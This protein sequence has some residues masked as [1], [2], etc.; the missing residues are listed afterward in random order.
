[1]KLLLVCIS[2]EAKDL[3][4]H[5]LEPRGFDFI[6]Y[7]NPVKAMDNIDEISPELVIFSAE[8]F[9]R[10][11]KPF[12]RLLRETRNKDESVF[13][14]LRGE[15]FPVDEAAKATHLG[16]NGIVSENLDDKRDIRKLEDLFARYSVLRDNRG[17]LRWLPEDTDDVEFLFTHP[18]TLGI[19][20]GEVIDISPEGISFRPDNPQL[21]ADIMPGVEV[22]YCTLRV[23]QK[24]ISVGV[25]LVRN[26]ELMAFMYVDLDT[27]DRLEIIQYMNSKAE[28][29]LKDRLYR[30][31]QDAAADSV[32]DTGDEDPDLSL[33]TL[34]PE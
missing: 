18:E 21:T 27:R 14:L 32:G 7:T 30:S 17:V 16:V 28:R 31:D 26:N 23:G 22:P 13:V 9:P 15:Y 8:E 10:H 5:Y 34:D 1:M 4:S 3:L 11:W 2:D 19:I 20:T 24:V 12:V 6:H 25:K 33:E 29:S